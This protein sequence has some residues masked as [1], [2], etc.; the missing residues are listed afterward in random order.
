[1]IVAFPV[2]TVLDV[3]IE[4]GATESTPSP[5]FAEF[6]VPVGIAGG[7]D[8]FAVSRTLSAIRGANS[9][10][11]NVA[12]PSTGGGLSCSAALTIFFT[13]DPLT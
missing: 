12:N 10:Y 11:L 13:T 1:V 9:V 7:S 5:G 2:G 6:E 3:T 8:S 4:T